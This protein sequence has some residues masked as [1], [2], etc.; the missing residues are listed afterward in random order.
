MIIYPSPHSAR[1]KA[2]RRVLI[3]LLSVAAAAALVTAPTSAEGQS[4]GADRHGESQHRVPDGFTEQRTRVGDISINYVRGGHGPTLVLVHGFPQT[5]YEWRGILPE[6]ARHYTVIAPDLR[7][8]G[9]SDAPAGGYDKKTMA[10]DIHGLLTKL[11]LTRDI[12]LVGHDIGTMVAYAYAAA[13][14]TEVAKLVLSEAPIPD[15]SIYQFP[16]LTVDGPAAWNFGFFSLRN[17]LPEK[18]VNGREELWVDLFID[19]LQVQKDAIGPEDIREFAGYLRDAAHLRAS[20]EWFRAFPTDITDNARYAKTKLTMPVLALGAS[21]SLRGSVETQVSNYANNVTGAV[22]A[23][24]GHWIYEEHPAELT[25]R[26]LTFL[27]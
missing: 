6:L 15:E 19:S 3:T 24:S 17:G 13:H 16:S 4:A 11:G 20:F 8:A 9:R 5:W 27:G 25:Q 22:I 23:S 10:A 14:P 12:R 26:L 2:A 21:N 18:L 1:R 7:G